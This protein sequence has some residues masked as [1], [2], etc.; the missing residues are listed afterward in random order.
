MRVEMIGPM[1]SPLTFAPGTAGGGPG[2][3]YGMRRVMLVTMMVDSPRELPVV[4]TGPDV[5]GPVVAGAGAFARAE[6]PA[7]A[8]AFARAGVLAR[9]EAL[10]HAGGPLV[11]SCPVRA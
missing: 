2:E 6:A 8:G 4:P 11:E 5:T 3:R 9:A 10:T 1:C 7:Q